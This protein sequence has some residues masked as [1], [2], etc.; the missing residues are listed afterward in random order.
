MKK[1]RLNK[2]FLSHSHADKSFVQRLTADLRHKGYIVWLDEAEIR[3]GDSL[4]GKI[5]EAIDNV[6]Y[7]IAVI[8]QSSIQ[9]EWVKHELDIAMNIEIQQKKVFVL[10]ILI[11]DVDLPG[12]LKGKLYADFRNNDFYEKELEKVL[13]KLG[14]VPESPSYSKEQFNKLKAEYE[15]VKA[16]VDFHIQATEQYMKIKSG[17]RSPDVQS[18]IEKANKEHPEFA[19]INNAYAFEMKGMVVTLGYLLWALNKSKRRGAH[20]LEALLTLENKWLEAQV[21]LKAYSDY[22]RLDRKKN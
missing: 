6:D 21:M 22:L 9:S 13:Q 8:S 1:K 4:I 20:P 14:P 12:F 10:P 2:I 18:E 16:F 3:V 17:Q 11:D 7:V 15:E 19:H 5:R